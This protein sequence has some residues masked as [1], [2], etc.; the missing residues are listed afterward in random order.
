MPGE[1][2]TPSLAVHHISKTFGA[3]TALK[4]V[5][6]AVGRGEIH[7]LLGGN[8]SGK[9]TLIKILA[10][11]QP[12]DRGT[13]MVHGTEVEATA[14]S[15]GRAR[16][17]G[18]RFVHQQS[19][20]FGPL[21]VTE[22]LFLDGQLRPG[23][24]GGIRWGRLRRQAAAILDE[25]AIEASPDAE[26]A[27]LSPA[28]QTMVAIARALW[29]T[30]ESQSRVLVLDEPTA[31]LPAAEVDLLLSSL[32]R[33][34]EEGHSILFVTHRLEEVLTVGDSITVLRDGQRVATLP[35]TEVSHDRLVT[36]I[37]GRPADIAEHREVGTSARVG[38]LEM[39]GIC[40]GPLYDVNLRVC[41]GEVVGVA[42]LL[43]SGR[44]TLLEVA[45]G[46]RQPVSG[47]MTLS[48]TPYRPGS[49]SHAMKAGVA[50]VPEDRPREAAFAELTVADNLSM[51][52]VPR[53][54]RGFTLRRRQ[55][56]RDARA[57]SREFLVRTAGVRALMSSLS[58]GNQQ[59]VILGRW[60]R[61]DPELLLLDEPSQGVDVGAKFEL[62]QL[63]RARVDAGTGVLVVSSDYEELA[64]VCDRVLIL[65]AGRVVRE[66]SGD[67]LTDTN[68][69]SLTLEAL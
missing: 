3:T 50:Y 54:F 53:Y 46:L 10:G 66:V 34:A 32:R 60:L 63:I 45:F 48:G 23:R 59:K 16:A 37:L 51:A 36:L 44:S 5:S 19:S 56:A 21:T 20:T 31:S 25:F 64:A 26:L 41:K 38:L 4:D 67:E 7:A 47:A 61:R 22:N 18:L 62:W 49:P 35:R 12:A 11:I 17:L 1:Q 40:T 14:M 52:V 69:E 57:V 15:T 28:K 58:G 42:G 6:F 55:E 2:T 65:A 8:G 39:Q 27:S 33:Y 43:G 24:L 68:L 30:D 9:S 29:N 13:V